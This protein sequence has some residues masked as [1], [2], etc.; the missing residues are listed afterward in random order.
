[1]QATMPNNAE[2]NSQIVHSS[3][4]SIKGGKLMG[5][6]ASTPPNVEDFG[7]GVSDY[8]YEFY[9]VSL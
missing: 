1:M 4:L 3:I 8:G 2:H 7:K 6:I 5:W 9:I